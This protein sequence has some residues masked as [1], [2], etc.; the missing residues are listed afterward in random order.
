MFWVQQLWFLWSEWHNRIKER[1]N[2]THKLVVVMGYKEE[3]KWKRS[4]KTVR[5]G[6]WQIK[7][8]KYSRHREGKAKKGVQLEENWGVS[9]M[10]ESRNWRKGEN[11][12][13]VVRRLV[14]EE[15][16]EWMRVPRITRMN[17]RSWE[18]YCF[19]HTTYLY[20]AVSLSA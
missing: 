2:I 10:K 12:N 19:A 8:G 3:G 18:F 9:R 13:W 16:E 14:W 20:G 5:E 15:R 11:L 17:E 1:F 7:Q 4:L 6:V